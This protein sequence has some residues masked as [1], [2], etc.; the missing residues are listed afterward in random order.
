MRALFH[1][2]MGSTFRSLNGILKHNTGRLFTLSF[3]YSARQPVLQ[4]RPLNNAICFMNGAVR[5]SHDVKKADV[6]ARR[7]GE[8]R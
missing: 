3:A 1:P 8:K 5:T 6:N 4:I 2:L 7:S